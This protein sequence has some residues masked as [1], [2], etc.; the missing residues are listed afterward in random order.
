MCF[1]ESFSSF[2]EKYVVS[3]MDRWFSRMYNHLYCSRRSYP[4]NTILEDFLPMRMTIIGSG[5]WI[6][7]E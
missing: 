2:F 5:A 6:S 7:G 3:T 4:V 1:A